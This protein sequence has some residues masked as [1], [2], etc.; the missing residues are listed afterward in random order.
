MI[1]SIDDSYR[2]G[3]NPKGLSAIFF[4]DPGK[5]LKVDL[6]KNLGVSSVFLFFLMASFDRK[7][8]LLPHSV[9]EVSLVGHCPH[10]KVC[11]R[12]SLVHSSP[13]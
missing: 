9:A 5:F 1:F 3:C 10:H 12:H 2:V 6:V 8:V 4:L 13:F 7:G 11:F